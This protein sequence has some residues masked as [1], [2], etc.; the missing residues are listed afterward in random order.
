MDVTSIFLAVQEVFQPLTLLYLA[1]GVFF[2]I[3]AGAIPGFTFTMAIILA[4]PFTF[5]MDPITGLTLMI[6]IYI[7]GLSGGLISGTLLGIPGTPSSVVTIFDGF[8][9]AK[10]GEGSR[11]LGIGIVSSVLGTIIGAIILFALGP[12]I[13]RVA[14]NFGPWEIFALVVFALTLIAGL[15][16]ANLIKGLI[17]GC[18]GLLIGTV[19]IA[20]T[21]QIRFDFGYPSLS[22]GLSAIPVLIGLF[23]FSQLF[24]NVEEI[25]EAYSSKDKA[26][27]KSKVKIP[28]LQVIKD[29]YKEKWNVFRSSTIGCFIGALPAAGAESA[30]FISYDRAKKS[31]KEKENFGKG[32][33]GGIVAAESSNNAVA[34]GAFIPTITLGIPGDVAQAV[35]I[36]AL[37]L[38]GI[39]P[40]PG[41]FQQQPVLVN[42]IYVAIICSA[43]FVLI[44]QTLL[45]PLLIRITLVPKSILIPSILVLS[46]V[47]AFA[48]NNRP[49]DIWVVFVFGL[50]GFLLEKADVPLGPVILG[51][52]LGPTLEAELIRAFQISPEI[53]TFFTRPISLVF[54]LLAI[55]S[56]F[57]TLRQR[58]K[59]Q[60]TTAEI[61]KRAS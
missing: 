9:M 50:V 22:S 44:I 21:G 10:R 33:P 35:M 7:G 4:F 61:Q 43:I 57:F 39:T 3:I 26:V 53:S 47:G 34:G 18:I 2:G 51:L 60:G 11:A 40:G 31:S 41:L 46:T 1:I 20:P 55:G 42:S 32:H 8:P 19:G 45:L 14:L 56:I 52:I 27:L 30:N 49:F 24:K 23:A 29:V 25:K 38:H 17:A 54:L 28:Y 13:S 59:E 16:G 48:L 12:V 58:K 6:G 5:G 15:S 36:G 37:I